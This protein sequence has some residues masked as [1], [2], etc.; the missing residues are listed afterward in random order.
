M[1]NNITWEV[2]FSDFVWHNISTY[3][4][5]FSVF[6]L[7]GIVLSILYIRFLW[8]K[9]VFE[10]TPK[11]YNWAVKLYIP[12]LFVI[13][14]YFSFQLAFLVGTKKVLHK[15][16]E[17]I[18]E[19]VYEIT[20][21]KFFETPK[22][23]ELFIKNLQEFSKTLQNKSDSFD[24]KM[25][26]WVN[27]NHDST[28]EKS[29][30]K[31][32]SFLL[33]KYKVKLYTIALYNLL[34]ISNNKTGLKKMSYNEIEESIKVFNSLDTEQIEKSIKQEFNSFVIKKIDSEMHKLIQGS[35]FVFFIMILLPVLDWWIYRWWMRREIKRIENQQKIDIKNELG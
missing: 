18:V 6:V 31:L 33:K 16:T 35:L 1:N 25:E 27:Q 34:R 22:D 5:Y 24:I 9:K 17:R 21:S 26:E 3:A 15:E 13:F 8:K 10:R 2:I 28:R 12:F 19:E 23:R 4:L 20:V 32:T 14:M 29:E 7:A 30:N 11:Y